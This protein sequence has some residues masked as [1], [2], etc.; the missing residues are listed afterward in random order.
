MGCNFRTQILPKNSITARSS[1]LRQVTKDL[2]HAFMPR[3]PRMLW[4]LAGHGREPDEDRT[5]PYTFF[6]CRTHVCIPTARH[7]TAAAVVR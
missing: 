1:D 7:D 2:H 6:S 5:S 4:L 3:G